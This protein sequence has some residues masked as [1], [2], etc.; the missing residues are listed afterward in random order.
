MSC[1]CQSCLISY[2]IVHYQNNLIKCIFNLFSFF[3]SSQT[4]SV[5]VISPTK[6]QQQRQR[7]R[8][9]CVL[10]PNHTTSNNSH[11]ASDTTTIIICTD[12]SRCPPRRPVICRWVTMKCKTVLTT[13]RHTFS[14]CSSCSDPTIV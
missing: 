12:T 2:K 10:R 11:A 4:G 7:R 3:F 13:Y 5:N 14:P 8:R 9:C 1:D 6:D